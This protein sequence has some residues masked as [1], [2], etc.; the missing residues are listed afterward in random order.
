MKY[1]G[2]MGFAVIAALVVLC[3]L[4]ATAQTFSAQAQV[5]RTDVFVGESLRLQIH[6]S[7][8]ESPDRPDVAGMDGLTVRYLGGQKNSSQSVSIIN[9]RISK[10]VR[11]GYV[12][13]FELTPTRAG[14]LVIPSIP[15]SGE[16]KVAQTSPVSL[17]VREPMETEDFKLRIGLSKEQCYTGEAITL[18]VTWYLVQDV[19][20]FDFVLP[21]LDSSA[22]FHADPD[23]DTSSGGPYYRIP[24]GGGEVIGKK[25]RGKLDGKDYATITFSKI[26]IPRE[27]G[28]LTIEP[29]V[30]SCEAL[31]GYR[32]RNRRQRGLFG[33]DFMSNFFN[34]DF[35]G[36]RREGV[37]RRVSV[38]SNRLV[39]EVLPQ[40]SEGRPAGFSGHVGE[41]SVE[42][43][44]SPVDVSVGD[45][46]TLNILVG[47]PEY[48]EHVSL[49]PLDRQRQLAGDFRIP[50]EMAAGRVTGG[51]KLFTQTIRALRPDVKKVPS[52]ELPYFDV[53]KR[54]Y[55]VA[56]SR[57]IPL[58][59]RA[60]KVVTAGDA[61]GRELTVVPGRTLEGWS[62][63]IAYNYDGVEIL[64]DHR[65]GLDVW[66][67]S[68]LRLGVIMVP[69]AVYL[70][71]L[72]TLAVIRRRN[73]DPLSARSRRAMRVLLRSLNAADSGV[74]GQ[75]VLDGLRAYVGDKLGLVSSALTFGDVCPRLREKGVGESTLEDLKTVF[76]EC[77]A[78]TY[79]GGAHAMA[80][81]ELRKRALAV[82]R[83][84]EKEL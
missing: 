36:R 12:F 70:V 78:G 35:F 11:K 60:A 42:A 24:L 38:P 59:V 46:I 43:T 72:L 58:N 66:L 27:P 48:L 40:P 25:G 45:P 22:V 6:V 67:R 51:G 55:R 39:L 20:S 10:Q 31:V 2:T 29:A 79:A 19:R 52:I 61:E 14:S 74:P 73:A 63:G 49:P 9:G 33:D 21:V 44:A 64:E 8:S 3:A 56:R 7:G 28:P 34:D 84:L 68:S 5:S 16:G 76:R 83:R 77:E 37:Y 75:A 57:P 15:V 30:V 1:R 62:A 47:G 41:Y 23:I 26:L 81:D 32:D 13:V 4:P 65:A 69:P 17:N 80:P 54:E 18:T 82:A 71:A 53:A 50:S